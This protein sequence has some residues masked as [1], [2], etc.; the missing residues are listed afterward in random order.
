[1]ETCSVDG[2]EKRAFSGGW[3]NTHWRRW[4]LY[5][6][7]DA[8][9]LRK[10]SRKSK[11]SVADCDLWSRAGGL[12]QKHYRRKR[13]YGDPLASAPRKP[14][15]PV[16]ERFWS[17]V[18][19]GALDDCWEWQGGGEGYGRFWVDG[20][21]LGSH[22]FSWELAN[23]P[24]PKGLLV[25]HTCDNPPCVNPAHLFLGTSTDNN[26]DRAAK[27]RSAVNRPPHTKLST[28]DVGKIR[29]RYKAGGVT[30]Y[31]LADEYGVTQGHISAIV[32]GHRGGSQ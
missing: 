23:G 27:G 15:R 4:K 32:N 5:G 14:L 29:E 31:Q 13:L 12:C 20:R 25:C 28:E 2:C 19:R 6:D 9:D 3:C 18:A 7:L 11:C 16:E 26:R 22:R 24:V 21:N 1:M 17:F 10:R 30:Q 8:P